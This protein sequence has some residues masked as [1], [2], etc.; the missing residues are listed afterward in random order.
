MNE[1][2]KTLS[3]VALITPTS[4]FADELLPH[5]HVARDVLE[6]MISI[7][8]VAF[9]GATKIIAENTY[10]RLIEAG[11]KDEDV[12]II[13]PEE[14]NKGLWVRY[15]GAV[16]GQK[17]ILTLAHLDIVNALPEDWTLPPFSLIEQEGYFYGRGVEDNK[18]G[19]ATLVSTFIRLKEEGFKPNRD[20]I[21]WLSSDEE[22]TA[23]S[24]KWILENHKDMVDAE[25]A[26]NTDA[27]GGT[28]R[29]GVGVNY[30]VQASEK[31]YVTFNFDVRNK[32]GHSSVPPKGNAIYYLADALKNLE[33]YS[34]PIKTNEVT[35]SY[36]KALSEK[37]S[38]EMKGL[39]VEASKEDGNPD[40]FESLA[41]TSW[42]NATLRTT[43]VATMLH[44]GHA[45]NAL[46]QLARA[47]VNCRV[48]PNSDPDEVEATLRE[49]TNPDGGN[50]VEVIRIYEPTLSPPSPIREDVFKAITFAIHNDYPDATII[51]NMSTGAT[52]GL[53]FRNAGIP[54]YGTSGLFGDENTGGAHGQ[55]EN[56]LVESY[57]Q[58]QDHWY[59][60]LKKLTGI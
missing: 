55:N 37:A 51:P 31:I 12:K 26:L 38:P 41:E 14:N 58:A 57:Y 11:F 28:L 46:P 3:L 23:D 2:L 29:D 19:A 45:E 10:K 54:V 7:K 39:M 13:G 59:E 4:V 6:E 47:T 15:R 43:C 30:S 34:F 53:Y 25:Y 60:I 18:A 22:D 40:V 32:G 56:I 42:F 49:I 27:G 16:G 33:A 44:G 8:S 20:I 17:P 52:D 21:M 9:D 50:L 1:F 48:L 24:T 35:R 5:Q 36:F